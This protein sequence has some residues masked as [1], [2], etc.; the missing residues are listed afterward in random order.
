MN[1]EI[2]DELLDGKTSTVFV[3]KVADAISADIKAQRRKISRFKYNSLINRAYNL[4]NSSA[5][6]YG[7]SIGAKLVNNIPLVKGNSYIKGSDLAK[8]V[9]YALHN[10]GALQWLNLRNV[11]EDAG[12]PLNELLLVDAMD[13]DSIRKKM[14]S[15]LQEMDVTLPEMSSKIKE[16]AAALIDFASIIEPIENTKNELA[17]KSKKQGITIINQSNTIVEQHQKLTIQEEILKELNKVIIRLTAG[18]NSEED[19]AKVKRMVAELNALQKR[20]KEME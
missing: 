20:Q 4:S 18:V 11:L 17:L 7:H 15:D 8:I 5:L 13:M 2:F 16:M 6:R 19:P 3:M 14:Q 12:K 1:F 9:Y 10:E